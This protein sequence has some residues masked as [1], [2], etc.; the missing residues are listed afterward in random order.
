M[1][2]RLRAKDARYR[3]TDWSLKHRS[4]ERRSYELFEA[5]PPPDGEGLQ[6][7]TDRCTWA[8]MVWR[9]GATASA[10]GKAL[11]V[12]KNVVMGV[13]TREGW[14]RVQQESVEPVMP[15]H[16]VA[17]DRSH[18]AWVIGDPARAFHYCG[19]PVV[20]G[21]PYC[22]AHCAR[23]YINWGCEKDHECDDC[24]VERTPR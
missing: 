19:E 14:D 22:E 9:M 17:P 21:K 2:K 10:I 18:C 8:A 6:R 20:P 11:G 13:R 12:S 7:G 23:A 16:L 4:R 24:G 1:P 15:R 3:T 5:N